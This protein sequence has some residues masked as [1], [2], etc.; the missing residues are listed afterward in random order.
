M[1]LLVFHRLFWLSQVAEGVGCERH[2]RPKQVQAMAE[3]RVSAH[4]LNIETLR[5]VRE[6]IGCA[7]AVRVSQGRNYYVMNTVLAFARS[8]TCPLH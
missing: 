8:T 2:M 7:L 6:M 3:M 1:K 5:H 4:W